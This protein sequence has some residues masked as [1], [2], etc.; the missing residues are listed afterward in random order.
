MRQFV[1]IGK[2]AAVINTNVE[3][4]T[5]KI[6]SSIERL[7]N[8][9][10]QLKGQ[11]IIIKEYLTTNKQTYDRH[12]TSISHFS[13]QVENCGL[14][15]SGARF[16]I[17]GFDENRGMVS[18]ERTGIK[19][20]KPS[21][22]YEISSYNLVEVVFDRNKITLIENLSEKWTRKTEIIYTVE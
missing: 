8:E 18:D 6:A 13:L 14:R 9:L 3:R 16:W 22:Y 12:V 17:E 10:E 1:D 21:A 19:I 20:I 11:N 7:Y 5:V 4:D 15:F 2:A